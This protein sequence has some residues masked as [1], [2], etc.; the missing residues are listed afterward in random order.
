MS[1]FQI[2]RADELLQRLID[3]TVARSSL[4]DLV[5]GS[6]LTQ[7]LGATARGLEGLYFDTARLLELFSFRTARGADLDARAA[8]V[9]PDGVARTG[10]TR[11]VGSLR[12]TRAVATATAI[13]VPAGTQVARPDTG[14]VYVTTAPGWIPAAGTQSVRTDGPGGDIPARAVT[15]GTKGNC[16]AGIVT[17]PLTTIAGSNAVT[18]PLPFSG[19]VDAETDDAFRARI[20]QRTQNLAHCTPQALEQRALETNLDGHVVSTAKFV[21]DPFVPAFGILYIDDGSG[22]AESFDA[23]LADEI[24]VATATGGESRFALDYWPLREDAW[25]VTYTPNGDPDEVLVQD[26]DF[27]IIPSMGLL[28]L[29]PTVFPTGLAAGDALRIGP[30]T[31]F[32]GLIAEAQRLINGD[33]SDADVVARHAA[34]VI[35][36]VRTPSVRWIV[37]SC[38]IA[39]LDGYDLDTVAALVRKEI[40]AYVNSLNIGDDVILATLIA[41]A[42]A[43]AG[44]FNVVFDSP[45][46]DTPVGDIEIARLQTGNLE[47]NS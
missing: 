34:G 30:Y 18:N 28:V 39:V 16:A 44:M 24:L 38:S 32:T 29:S 14:A 10:A 6:N 46:A 27:K 5:P 22:N 33:P 4:T 13:I 20:I 40:L 31:Y 43:P 15:L 12:W 41:R 2:R 45:A 37:V 47:V 7:V 1:V 17:K 23:T 11:A 21:L 19:A 42:M 3:Y 36:R 26:T 35:I 9:L 25:T 8:E